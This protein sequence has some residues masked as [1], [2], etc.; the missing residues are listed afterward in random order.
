M[1]DK[2]G[3]TERDATERARSAAD[4][5]AADGATASGVD[6][7]TT[8]ERAQSVTAQ[9]ATAT[10]QGTDAQT[11]GSI[12]QGATDKTATAQPATERTRLAIGGMSCASC[13]ASIERMVGRMDGVESMVVN[14]AANN[15]VVTL[16]PA[17][18][19][20]DDV[21][22]TIERLD[23]TAEPI[24][25]DGRAAFD[26]ERRAKEAAADRRDLVTFVVAL[27]LTVVIVTISMTPLGMTAAMEW[28]RGVYGADATHFQAMHLMNIA[29][30]VL[31]IPVQFFCGARYY[32]GAWG[33]LKAR[34]GNMDTLVAVGTT[35][36]FVY[37][38]YLTFGPRAYS[39]AMAPFE[40]S[41]M[42]ITF[43]LLGKMLEHRARGRA[44]AAVEQLMGLAPAEAWIRR[45]NSVVSV[46]QDMVAVGDV[47]VVRPGERVP[48]DGRVVSGHSSVDESML[49]GEP[50]FQEKS[51]GDEVTGGTV[52]GNGAFEFEVTAA[53]ADTTLAHIV[54]LVEA[55][56][57][58]KPPIQRLADK[59]SA[60]FV[61]AVLLIALATFLVWLVVAAL[62]GVLDAAGFEHA[63]MAGVAVV[64]VACPCALGLATPTAIMVGTGRGAEEGILIK[65]GQALE[66]A[67]SLDCVIFDKT[68]T[69]TE[70]EPMVVEVSC[71]DGTGRDEALALAAGL[72]RDSEHPLARAVLVAAEAEG[73]EPV[74]VEGFEA[75]P[76]HGVVGT[77]NGVAVGFGN[78]RLVSR[79]T[80]APVPPWAQSQGTAGVT[81]MYLVR[82]GSVVARVGAADTPKATAA[83]GVA[84][85][86]EAGLQVMLLSG[87]GRAAAEGVAA[88]VGIDPAN[89]IAEV[90]PGDKASVVERVQAEG[91]KVCMVGD[92]INDT[93]AL[94]TA[95][96]GIAMGAGSDAALEVGQV[97]LMHD[98]VRDVARAVSLSRA[99]MRKIRQNFA[100]A[101]G[102]NCLLIPLACL[103]II[104]PE[105]SGA[106]MA[107]SSVSVVTN[108]LLLKR[109]R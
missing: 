69:L 64:V 105:V 57:G 14:L 59:I 84:A 24:P 106:A 12:E 97:V 68:G 21:I 10:A 52:N 100:W 36:A 35:V 53:G 89:V 66:Q 96:I 40:T 23:F 26:R 79:L 62:M 70:G 54:E 37:A 42:L 3:A 71:A 109:W 86:K 13:S 58:S 29:C 50:V 65:D 102:Y 51:A 30:L 92:G 15:G 2:Q 77:V 61:P 78:E 48:A 20:V 95:D 33:A 17:K 45:D 28:A 73:V 98:D 6:N 19:S 5:A 75:V 1:E 16:D 90:L 34:S 46:P 74:A 99:T 27:V 85:L 44:G 63:L 32:R 80:G 82:D 49:T 107:L 76:G 31:C 47:C 101:L 104:A 38:V 72:E 4:K 83:A 56:Q 81:D 18:T 91:K 88:Q 60:V 103:G 67:G 55:A 8:V 108:S 93:P 7:D 22:A 11:Q 39:G 94:A 41:A 9:G 25:E 87:D 43:V